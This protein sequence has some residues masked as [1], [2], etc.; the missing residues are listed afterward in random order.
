MNI[1]SLRAEN[2]LRLKAVHI[3][4]DQGQPLTF[5]GGKNFQG[6]SSV[7]NAIQ[8]AMGGTKGFVAPVRIGADQ[9][10][11]VLELDDLTIKR[12]ISAEGKETLV[13][14]DRAGAKIKSPQKILDSLASKIAYDPLEFSRMDAAKQ[15]DTLRKLVGIDFAPLNLKRKEIWDTREQKG[16]DGKSLASRVEAMPD[17]RDVPEQEV[18]VADLA[19]KLQVILKK[20]AANDAIR[21]KINSA[22]QTAANARQEVLR[23]EEALRKAR[24]VLVSADA[25][26]LAAKALATDDLANSDTM[27]IQKQLADSDSINKRVRENAEKRKLM[28]E[29]IIAR[30]E[31]ADL[32]KQIG[33]VDKEK[34]DLVA[35]ATFPVPELSFDENGIFYKS[36]P[37]SQ[38]SGAEQIVVSVA[39]GLA[40]N[41]T[42]PVML[43]RDGSNIDDDMMVVMGEM[44]AKSHAQIWIERVGD[45]DQTAVI[46]EDGMVKERDAGAPAVGGA[47]RF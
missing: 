3:V 10:D 4:P 29:M 37:F 26:V 41:P 35:N 44:A 7:L 9:G 16:R 20:N 47:A 24:E 11:I 34:A 12:T 17:H 45:R 46:I 30:T 1:I 36:V 38:A 43:I 40:L 31:Y 21:T 27:E 23:A 13:V 18:S 14:T 19:T 32:T 28:G 42:L 8:I 15:L 39:I 6:K 22:E 5:I 25:G 2:I 33:A